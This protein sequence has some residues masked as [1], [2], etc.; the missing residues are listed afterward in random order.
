MVSIT[1]SIYA[2]R[3]CKIDIQCGFRSIVFYAIQRISKARY[4]FINHINIITTIQ[5][6]TCICNEYFRFTTPISHQLEWNFRATY[7]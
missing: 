6:I 3:I 5:Q 1:Y 2:E 4:W 7:R